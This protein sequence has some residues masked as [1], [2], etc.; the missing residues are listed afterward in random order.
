MTQKS[1]VR[2][3]V[4]AC[5][6][7]GLAG[8]SFLSSC[9]SSSSS[10]AVTPAQITCADAA[11]FSGGGAPPIPNVINSTCT[12][13]PYTLGNLN[14]SGQQKAD[15]YS[16]LAFVSLNWPAN[17][18]TCSPDG[19]KSILSDY[20]NPT[21]LTYLTDDDVY[22]S[23]GSPA[24][25]CG[26]STA[27]HGVAAR[28]QAS[29]SHY[30]AAVQK[31]LAA[32]PD[33]HL[34][35]E[36]NAKGDELIST[37][38]LLGATPSSTMQGILQATGQP[39]VDQNGR[40]VRFTISMNQ[41]EYNYV[42]QNKLYTIPGQKATNPINFP[43]G[44]SPTSVG[45]IEIKAAWK[46][47]GANDDP[48]R[49]FTQRAIVFNNAQGA[50]SPGANPVTVGLVGLHIA[51]KAQNQTVWAWSTFEQVDNDSKSFYNPNCKPTI[52][53]HNCKPNTPTAGQNSNELG[54]TGAPLNAPAQ[55]KPYLSPTSPDLNST[56][57]AL[58]K[59]TPWQ[60]YQ[61]IGTQWSN[62]AIGVFPH[63]L[64][65]SVQ[66]TF[67][68]FTTKDGKPNS[69]YSC[70]GCHS[71]ATAVPGGQASDMSFLVQAPLLKKK[72]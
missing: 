64:G 62:G 45:A 55:V 71:F 36:H 43:M 65:N 58:L 28:L 7:V 61:L 2:L 25:W 18:S 51:H 69:I 48:S 12:A 49:F 37:I 70:V 14:A 21:W 57:Q 22:V 34:I 56:F 1:I 60:Y 11:N 40:F 17:D 47:L 63:Q 3:A 15:L 4:L 41:D 44:S 39:L 26:G 19:S 30:P 54:P 35:L 20:N 10:T 9:K 67:V 52:G 66:E 32:N 27:T 16:W 13:M 24:P 46:V 42:V 53:N 29:Q 59:G 31:L 68:P 8:V 33:V 5:L 72:K 38:H 6:G 50:P 23:S